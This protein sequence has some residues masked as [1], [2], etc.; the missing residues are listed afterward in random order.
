LKVNCL[1]LA[2]LAGLALGGCAGLGTVAPAVTPAMVAASHGATAETL[3]AGRR[4]FATQCTSCH[5]ADPISSRSLPQW[6]EV[7]SEMRT[8]AKLSPA[9]EAALLTYIAAVRSSS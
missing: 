2:A 8:R 6:R 7:V 5:S 4:V 1:K 3:N 9:Q